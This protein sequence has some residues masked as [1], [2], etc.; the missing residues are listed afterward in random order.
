MIEGS[1]I[2][3]LATDAL[4]I[5]IPA[6]AAMTIE[7]IRRK[8]GTEKMRHIQQ[9]LEAKQD[10]SIIAVRYVE[11][12]YK[13]LHGADKFA[14]AAN[15]LADKAKAHGLKI[16]PDEIEVLIESGIRCLKDAYSEE[17]TKAVKLE[18]V[19]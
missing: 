12:A 17:W 14:L 10:L 6:V 11:Q 15:W 8:M 7:F 1:L 13:D 2:T 19:K 9:E 18:E 16:S 5:L 3:S 4:S